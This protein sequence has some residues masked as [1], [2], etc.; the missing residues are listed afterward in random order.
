M[1]EARQ[2]NELLLWMPEEVKPATEVI[3]EGEI[4]LITLPNGSIP[5]EDKSGLG[6][7]CRDTRFL[8][9]LEVSI[10]GS[11]PVF[12]SS[13]NKEGHFAQ[14]ELANSLFW[15]GETPVPAQSIHLRL[16]RAV[17]GG[18]LQRLRVTNF[19]DRQ[20]EVALKIRLGADFI[21][22]FEVRGFKRKRRGK[23]LPAKKQKDGIVFAYLGLDGIYRS[24]VASFYPPPHEIVLLSG[25]LAEVNYRL[26]LLP[27][28]KNYI[29]MRITPFTGGHPGTLPSS[30]PRRAVRVFT[31]N[32]PRKF[33]QFEEWKKSCASFRSSN[34]ILNR[35]LER[36]LS[37]LYSLTAVYQGLGQIIEAGVPWYAT[38]FG[39]DSLIT[40]WQSLLVNPDLARQT[41][42]F[43]ARFQGKKVD[44]WREEEPGKILHELRRGEMAG[45]GEIPHTP[46]YGSVD[47]TLWFIILLSEVYFWT[48]DEAFLLEMAAPLEKALGWCWKYGDLD[49]DGFIEYARR[50]K[51]GL[52][53]QGWKDSWNGV[54]DENGQLPKGP[55]ALVE[56]QGYYYYALMRAAELYCRLG[57]RKEAFELR[58]R[59]S[60]LRKKFLRHFWCPVKGYPCFALD[61]KKR[62]IS[63]VVSNAGH[64]LFT[65]ILGGEQAKKVAERL[66]MPDMFSG[67][68]IRTMSSSEVAY[69]PMSYHNGSVWPHDN[70]IIAVGLKACGYDHLA[71]QIWSSLYRAALAFPHYRLPELFCGFS[72]RAEGGPV[73][74]P[75]ACSPQAWASGALFQLLTAVLG[76]CCRGADVYIKRPF[77]PSFADE[78]IVEN[79]AAG[80]GKVALEFTR[81]GEK[82]YCSVLDVSGDVRVIVSS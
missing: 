81:K 6:L 69:N 1:A 33:N 45:C 80:G 25:D 16:I 68:G 63:T 54:I 47:S 50:S 11:P 61:G 19:I 64:L 59:A 77:L 43:L 32:L 60:E 38:A 20:L 76:I 67:W 15:S 70:A 4:F 42:R 30:D 58:Y 12:L 72:R 51:S 75:V 65:G 17:H 56:V 8:S 55:I 73:H 40:A 28:K 23:L 10:A 82:T 52:I 79:V 39:R 34:Q 78:I 37:D 36:A 24:T 57:K 62:Q 5:R 53:N 21:D 44:P 41:I 13:L 66:F 35:M 2:E 71:A 31:R 3:K 48:G 7:Y 29:Y 18:F 49:G 27:Q 22:I 46:Y 14:I 9:C 74:Y 26:T